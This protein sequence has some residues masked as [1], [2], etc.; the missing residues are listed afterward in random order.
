MSVAI[1]APAASHTCNRGGHI[2][3]HGVR[4]PRAGLIRSGVS[5]RLAW[6]A[7][8]VLA[9]GA[10]YSCTDVAVTAVE[11]SRIKVTPAKASLFPGGKL[12]LDVEVTDEEG[13]LLP[14]RDIAWAS[15][16]PVVVTVSSEGMM[17]AVGRGSATVLA[18]SDGVTGWAVVTVGL[19][20]P[21]TGLTAT[22]VSSSQINLR[23]TDVS[24]GN[25]EYWVTRSTNGGRTWPSKFG[26]VPGN[27][28]SYQN[29]K[30]ADGT[31]YTYRVRA[32]EAGETQCSDYSNS[33][34]ATTLGGKEKDRQKALEEESD[35]DDD[36]DRKEET[37]NNK[38]KGKRG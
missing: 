18:S 20:P 30:L 4:S 9:A 33:A 2:P 10:G 27:A 29:T 28:A 13:R 3:L 24:M 25:D 37:K 22:V 16:D 15:T 23:W 32:C 35:D 12:R 17:T 36:E 21:P 34:G 19:G 1:P 6:G 31:T 14:N 38:N 26:P 7:V 5:R 11:V 8:G